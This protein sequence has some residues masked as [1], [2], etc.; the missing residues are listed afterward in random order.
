MRYKNRLMR[1]N[2]AL[3]RELAKAQSRELDW[4]GLL[5][6]EEQDVLLAAMK[7]FERLQTP[8]AMERASTLRRKL[9]AAALRREGAGK[10]DGDPATS[11]E[12]AGMTSGVARI[13]GGVAMIRPCLPPIV[14]RRHG[15]VV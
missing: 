3:S 8:E 12:P 14:I 1:V 5:T 9:Y 10:G 13:K 2:A 7:Q 15:P 4:L 6:V 11:L